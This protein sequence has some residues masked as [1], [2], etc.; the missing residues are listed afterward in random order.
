LFWELLIDQNLLPINIWLHVPNKEADNDPTR[1][2]ILPLLRNYYR[3]IKKTASRETILP[4]LPINIWSFG[5]SKN[6]LSLIT[7]ALQKW[8]AIRSDSRWAPVIS[9]IINILDKSE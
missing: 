1:T 8:F 6:D 2:E 7:P 4:M 3:P 9:G 5:E